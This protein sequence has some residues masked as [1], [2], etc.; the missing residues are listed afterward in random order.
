MYCAAA[1]PSALDEPLSSRRM[2]P[3]RYMKLCGDNSELST[4][5]LTDDSLPDVLNTLKESHFWDS[6]DLRFNRLTDRSS[7]L[8]AEFFQVAIDTYLNESS[9]RI[10]PFYSYLSDLE[11]LRHFWNSRI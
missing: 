10:P 5:R 1:K 11:F 8:F 2:N 3:T 7:I 4:E 9:F 6:L